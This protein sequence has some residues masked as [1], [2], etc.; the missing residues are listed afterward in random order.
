MSNCMEI[1]QRKISKQSISFQ[2][3][4][5]RKLETKCQTYILENTSLFNHVNVLNSIT[6]M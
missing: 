4:A 1:L 5:E 2:I 3:N 6:G